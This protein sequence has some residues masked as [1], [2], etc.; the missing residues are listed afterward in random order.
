M[1]QRL[2]QWLPS[3]LDDHCDTRSATVGLP[4]LRFLLTNHGFDIV[5]DDSERPTLIDYT[6]AQN[7]SSVAGSFRSW[8]TQKLYFSANCTCRFDPNPELVAI[9]LK[10]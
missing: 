4:C 2:H 6:V 10:V 9:V 7:E 8:R 5:Q 1:V 3:I